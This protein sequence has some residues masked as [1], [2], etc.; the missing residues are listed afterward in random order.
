MKFMFTN[1]SGGNYGPLE[2]PSSVLLATLSSPSTTSCL[3]QRGEP[4]GPFPAA[5][6]LPLEAG[7]RLQHQ[8]G[9]LAALPSLGRLA[10]RGP[11]QVRRLEH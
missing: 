4:H 6:L 3:L 8:Q 9:G 5:L 1:M 10:V 2:C 11:D 7:R